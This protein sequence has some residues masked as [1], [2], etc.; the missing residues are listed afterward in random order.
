MGF[1]AQ[2]RAHA[3]NLA[4]SGVDVVVGLRPGSGSWEACREAGLAAAEPA[5]AAN[6]ADVVVML[7]PD[8]DQPALYSN[9][10][11]SA[12][13]SG[14]ILVFAHGYNIHFGHIDPRP[15]LDVVMVAPLGIGEQVRR[16]YAAGGG[17]PALVSVARDASGQASGIALA[18]AKANGHGR[19]GIFETSFR[20]ETE[21]DL[22]AEQAVLCGG[23]THLIVAAYET[24]VDAGYPEE[25]AYFGC[26]HEVKLIADLV[27]ARG[28]AG[29][30]RSI[31]RTA[32]FGDYS[33]GPRV[34]NERSRAEMR[35]MLDDIRNGDFDR[36]LAAEVRS[37]YPAIRRGRVEAEAHSIEQVGERLRAMMPWL[38]EE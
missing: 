28:I 11:A 3:K 10:L 17:V 16:T 36:E 19:A 18:Y 9:V 2:G 23:L 14:S 15:D 1:G 32:E 33:R 13:R 37:G 20:E 4:D 12:M 34:I 5:A 31:S 27:H 25:L 24:L 29:M 35:R 21:T 38:A 7:V 22:F 26:L 30:R 6:T 8:A